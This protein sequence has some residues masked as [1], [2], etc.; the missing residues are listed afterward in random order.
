MTW[1]NA[2]AAAF[3][4]DQNQE[5]K[6]IHEFNDMFILIEDIYSIVLLTLVT[7]LRDI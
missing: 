6:N 3:A 7:S 4:A 2:A 5:L 1:F